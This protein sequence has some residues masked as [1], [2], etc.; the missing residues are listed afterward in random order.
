VLAQGENGVNLCD[1]T[2]DMTAMGTILAGVSGGRFI[3]CTNVDV[4]RVKVLS[5]MGGFGFIRTS[6]YSVQRCRF[7]TLAGSS[8]DGGI[9]DQWDGS[10][11]GVLAYNDIDGNSRVST[12]ILLTAADAEVSPTLTP[13]YAYKIVGNT[14]R[15]VRAAGIWVDG[16]RPTL[17]ASIGCH[18]ISII[19]NTIED[20]TEAYGLYMH[21]CYAILVEGN[22]VRGI[23]KSAVW[24]N[25]TGEGPK[26][27]QIVG[28]HFD[29]VNT[30]G[31][32]VASDGGTAIYMGTNA[33]RNLVAN[34]LLRGSAHVNGIAL[35]SGADNNVVDGNLFAA[36]TSASFPRIENGG[37]NNEISSRS[38]SSTYTPT[39]T[40]VANVSASTAHA[41][42]YVREGNTVF[43]SG[44]VEVTPSLTT[45][46]TQLGIS[47][48]VAS[49]FASSNT[50]CAGVAASQ[51][52]LLGAINADATNDRAQLQFQS[53]NTSNN[54]MYFT[55][56]YSV[57]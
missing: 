37:S 36:G 24:G 50:D 39:L 5:P 32:T 29:D 4:Q 20:V 30:S 22:I 25:G 57:I 1:F 40:S 27:S 18:D 6:F 8:T 14:I 52:A 2:I 28:N 31:Q 47:L 49:A 35:I 3:D 34:N 46:T 11:D 10:H 21:G 54:I 13:V 7:A 55:F 41:C 42:R 53:T 38:N 19:G 43:V 16:H 51:F 48:P 17:T 45:T 12:G 44:R 26:D 9:I 23:A 15:N 56:Q 33:D